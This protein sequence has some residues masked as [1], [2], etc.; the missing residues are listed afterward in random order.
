MH[1]TSFAEISYHLFSHER[2]HDEYPLWG[3]H[4]YYIYIYRINNKLLLFHMFAF[5][6]AAANMTRISDEFVREKEKWIA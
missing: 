2:K 5:Y 4:R 6:D 3:K 1:I